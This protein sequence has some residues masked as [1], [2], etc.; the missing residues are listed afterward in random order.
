MVLRALCL[1]NPSKPSTGCNWREPKLCLAGSAPPWGP[2]GPAPLDWGATM[3]RYPVCVNT[4]WEVFTLCETS[5]ALRGPP[6]LPLP[7][8][9]I[10]MVLRLD[11][12]PKIST[13][14]VHLGQSRQ[15]GHCRV[16]AL[17]FCNSP[18]GESAPF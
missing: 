8:S 13:T 4:K 14:I 3:L 7:F 5:G 10:S 11:D 18:K 9:L 15:A 16:A 17:T 1:R 6:P 2:V 12:S